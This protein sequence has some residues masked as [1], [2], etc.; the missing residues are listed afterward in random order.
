MAE[1]QL[2]DEAVPPPIPRTPTKLF[3]RG[4]P[5]VGPLLEQQ[6]LETCQRQAIMTALAEETTVLGAAKRLGIS[7]T[8][9][10]Q[11]LERFSLAPPTRRGRRRL[12][13]GL[14]SACRAGS[15]V[16]CSTPS[17]DCCGGSR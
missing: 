6:W 11:Y 10:Y 7:G 5:R 9:L 15:H 16:W 17:C 13:G 1:S 8:T 2:D 4:R 12:H 14:C 3:P